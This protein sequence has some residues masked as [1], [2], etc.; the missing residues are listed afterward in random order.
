MHCYC[1]CDTYRQSIVFYFNPVVFGFLCVQL[2]DENKDQVPYDWS[3]PY[4]VFTHSCG[5]ID[6]WNEQKMIHFWAKIIII[7]VL[8]DK[9]NGMINILIEWNSSTIHIDIV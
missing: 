5:P 6:Q 8:I 4:A 2:G 1:D 3:F 9:T 7:L